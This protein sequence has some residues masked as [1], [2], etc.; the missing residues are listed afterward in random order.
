MEDTKELERYVDQ[1]NVKLA[2]LELSVWSEI[3]TLAET[4]YWWRLIAG[5]SVLA[6]IG[7]VLFFLWLGSRS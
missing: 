4:L 6:N 2:Q 3:G 1:L 7:W 5:V